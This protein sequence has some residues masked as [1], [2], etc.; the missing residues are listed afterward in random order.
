MIKF[1]LNDTNASYTGNKN[2]SLL[3]FL[4]N[5]K[6]LIAA[7]DGCSGEGTCGACLVEID[8][9][10]KL[11]CKTKLADCEGK[12]II[13]LEGVPEEV[14]KVLGMAFVAKGGIQCGFCTPG[15]IMRTKILLQNNPKPTRDEIEKAIGLNLCRCT[16]YKKILDSIEFAAEKI[17]NNEDIELPVH[18]GKIGTSHPKYNS[19]KTAIGERPFVD[20]LTE[21]GML[22]S[23]L[24]YSEYP[25]ATIKAIDLS[26][27]EKVKGVVKIVTAKDIPGE[28]YIGLI[29]NDWPL[30]V[31]VGETTNYIGDVIAGVIAESEETAR[32]AIAKIKITYEVHT[33]ITDIH[34][35]AQDTIKVREN[36]SNVL[37]VCS[38]VRGEIDDAVK[39]SD[40]ISKGTYQTQRIEHAFLEKE[41]AFAK[42]DG[43]GIQLFSQ[44]QGIYEDRRQVARIL[45]LSEDKVRVILVPNGGGFGGKEDMTVQ[46]H[47][48]LHAYLTQKP[49]KLT[50][51]RQESIRMHPKRHPV[52]MEISA[53]CDKNGKITFVQLRALGD[54]GAYASVGTKVMERVAGHCTGGYYVPVVDLEAKTIYTNN[55]PCGAMRGFGANQASF[56]LEGCIDEL[57]E[58]GGFD[59]WKFRYDNALQDGLRTAT[60]QKLQGVG[61]KKSLE[62]VKDEFYNNKYTGIACAIKNSGIGNGMADFSDVKIEI[63]AKDR[64]VLHHGWTEMGQGVHTMALQS[65]VEETGIPSEFIEVLVDTEAQINT[66]MTTSSRG[67]VLVGNAIINAAKALKKD[68]KTKSLKELV[69]KSYKGKWVCDWTTK[70]GDDVEEPITHYSYGYATQLCVLNNNGEIDTLY[71]AHDAGKIMN[72]MLFEGQIEGSVHMGIGYALTESLPMKDGYLISDKLKDCQVLKAKDTPNIVVKGIEVHDPVGPYGAKGVGEIGLVP[73]AAAVANALYQYD[74]KRRFELPLK[75]K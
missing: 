15:F 46:G 1:T 69:G 61:I 14:K 73:T 66:G 8:G 19:Y 13:T 64:V 36:Q 50:L 31:D 56:A 38:F 16:G 30:M 44:S 24:L 43:E 54:T 22:F 51:S 67:T 48:A 18:T 25:K 75:R 52:Y 47:A 63:K 11:A 42:P 12:K 10:P 20:D 9:K 57:C 28:Q 17:R 59:R 4:R 6:N 70:P 3:H 65:L 32:D 7:K 40:Y 39:N 74:K 71:A 5:E 41:S 72:P 29:F 37:E 60:G 68:L 35:A 2:I 55:I 33:P 26:E 27:A 21:P 53:G 34:K 58:Q 62:A 45:G 49:V 23:A